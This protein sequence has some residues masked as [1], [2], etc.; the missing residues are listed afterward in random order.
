MSARSTANGLA[1]W[2]NEAPISSNLDIA[3]VIK[4]RWV[5]RPRAPPRRVR[6]FLFERMAKN[7]FHSASLHEAL[8]GAVGQLKFF[9]LPYSKNG[10]PVRFIR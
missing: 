8:I 9:Q 7:A 1:R 6:V 4:A 3:L 2:R 5:S 10:L